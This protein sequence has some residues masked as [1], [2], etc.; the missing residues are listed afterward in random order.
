[1]PSR[2]VAGRAG[3]QRIANME[4]RSIRV[5]VRARRIEGD[6]NQLH[7]L[8]VERPADG[9]FVTFSNA[10]LIAGVQRSS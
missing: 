7:G 8:A 6:E 1:M 3:G 9:S 10:A 4:A 2:S 5:K